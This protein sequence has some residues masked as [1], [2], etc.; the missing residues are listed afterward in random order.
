MI[1]LVGC[2]LL[3]LM[4]GNIG[5][6]GN[7]SIYVLSYFHEMH[8]KIGTD[9]IFL[10]DTLQVTSNWFGHALGAYLIKVRKWHP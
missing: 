6:W 9:F 1:T 5:I 7:V 4:L 3:M 2:A 8:G 10:V